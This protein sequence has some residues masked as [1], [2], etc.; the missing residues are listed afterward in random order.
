MT[1]RP[2]LH[3]IYMWLQESKK[4][5]YGRKI[6]FGRMKILPLVFRPYI[7]LKIFQFTKLK[8]RAL[9]IFALSLETGFMLT[10]LCYTLC[11]ANYIRTKAKLTLQYILTY[12]HSRSPPSESQLP[13]WLACALRNKDWNISRA[14]GKKLAVRRRV[15]CPRRSGC[16]NE[17][18]WKS[19]CWG[20]QIRIGTV[21]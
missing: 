3:L 11:R 18:G 13:W 20:S 21:Q 16:F 5:T 14:I 8:H 6:G 4:V 12:F 2:T 19:I 7:L 10:P 1:S 9:T 17:Q 15:A